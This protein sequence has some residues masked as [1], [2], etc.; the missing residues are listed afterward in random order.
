[1]PERSLLNKTVR[2][3]VDIEKQVSSQIA[4]II[5]CTG[6]LLLLVCDDDVSDDLVKTEMTCNKCPPKSS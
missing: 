6:L 2:K 1:M 3:V 5:L 4:F